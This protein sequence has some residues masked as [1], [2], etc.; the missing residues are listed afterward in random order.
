[1]LNFNVLHMDS[2]Y[3][4]NI[5]NKNQ[6]KRKSSMKTSNYKNGEKLEMKKMVKSKESEVLIS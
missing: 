2:F 6:Q 4:S 3:Y 5:R 1:M